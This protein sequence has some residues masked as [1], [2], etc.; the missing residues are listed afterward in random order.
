MVAF[1]WMVIVSY[2]SKSRLLLLPLFTFQPW[3][4]LHSIIHRG[5]ALVVRMSLSHTHHP[6]VHKCSVKVQ[7]QSGNMKVSPT[8]LP[9]NAMG[10][11]AKK[12]ETRNPIP[13]LFVKNDIKNGW[14]CKDG[15]IG[16]NCGVNFRKSLEAFQDW[17]QGLFFWETF[18][19]FLKPE[20][21]QKAP[22]NSQFFPPKCLQRN[23]FR[24]IK[25]FKFSSS[26]PPAL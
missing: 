13:D 11:G 3:H 10:I 12:R 23:S 16:S 20:Y 19:T 5:T 4:H 22:E 21:I 18:Q 2:W 6:M 7:Q 14:M 17:K 1:Y 25:T 9:T 26:V 15:W 8:D 24:N